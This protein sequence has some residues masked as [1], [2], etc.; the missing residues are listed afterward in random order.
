MVLLAPLL[1]WVL[2]TEGDVEI[3][4]MPRVGTVICSISGFEE[5][6]C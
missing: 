2:C 4:W 3:E 5:D 1:G 6:I